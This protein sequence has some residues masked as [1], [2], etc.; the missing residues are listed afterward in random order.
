MMSY[1]DILNSLQNIKT[2][3]IVLYT[4]RIDP[5]VSYHSAR[6]LLCL[7]PPLARLFAEEYGNSPSFDEDRVNVDEIELELADEDL[8][9]F[10]R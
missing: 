8:Q 10:P 6:I 7:I 3:L 4:S 1:A 2:C 5:S 9:D